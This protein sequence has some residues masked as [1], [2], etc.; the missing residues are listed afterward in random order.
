MEQFEN[1]FYSTHLELLTDIKSDSWLKSVTN[2]LL[3]RKKKEKNQRY[4]SD[5]V[6]YFEAVFMWYE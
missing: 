4:R 3:G 5:Y 2:I 6:Q 1:A